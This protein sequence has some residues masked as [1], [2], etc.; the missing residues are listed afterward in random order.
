MVAQQVKIVRHNLNETATSQLIRDF[1]EIN[2]IDINNW[3]ENIVFRVNF[4]DNK[5]DI[6]D[7][8]T[9]CMDSYVLSYLN[10][11]IRLR[12]QFEA[13]EWARWDHILTHSCYINDIM[14]KQKNKIENYKYVIR[15][16]CAKH[17]SDSIS[18]L[19]TLR[20][21]ITSLDSENSWY[22][23]MSRRSLEECKLLKQ[24]QESD[25]VRL[26]RAF[27]LNSLENRVRKN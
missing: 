27:V 1:D 20:T 19:K 23:L 26:T 13:T 4:T 11:K 9:N 21:H 7:W 8:I 2:I 25:R 3:F 24:I 10:S 18:Q 22:L 6:I 17:I 5:S 12:T 16:T 14:L 15:A